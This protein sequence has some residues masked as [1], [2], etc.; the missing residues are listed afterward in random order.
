M[1]FYFA[2]LTVE[3]STIHGTGYHDQRIARVRRSTPTPASAAV[4]INHVFFYN[5]DRIFMNYTEKHRK[6]QR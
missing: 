3:Y 6:R 5:G 4:T 1:L 2:S